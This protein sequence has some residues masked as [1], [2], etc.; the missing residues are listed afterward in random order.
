MRVC[1][2]ARGVQPL[3]KRVQTST[4]G[5]QSQR[6]AAT[7]WCPKLTPSS[8]CVLCVSAVYLFLRHVHAEA[9]RTQKAT[10]EKDFRIGHHQRPGSDAV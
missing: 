3:M 6:L 10:A 4:S 5:T 2:E 9:Q 8:L 7:G 1:R